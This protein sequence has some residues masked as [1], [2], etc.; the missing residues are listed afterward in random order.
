ME[1]LG[2]IQQERMAAI[3]DRRK[4]LQRK[5]IGNVY[6]KNLQYTQL[7]KKPVLKELEN[8]LLGY[9]DLD[10]YKKH[11]E[12]PKETTP[13]EQAILRDLQQPKKH[14]RAHEV[15]QKIM[16]RNEYSDSSSMQPLNETVT[17]K[18]GL[19]NTDIEEI[20]YLN[21]ASMELLTPADSS[22]NL[23]LDP[24]V[25]T[26]FGRSYVEL[27]RERLFKKA[28]ATYTTHAQMA[29]NGYRTGN[30]PTFSMTA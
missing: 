25:D 7:N 16:D 26:I 22:N 14:V 3:E 11:K 23:K 10:L 30:E 13:Q 21:D 24:F 29:K 17:S 2:V 20:A 5:N 28:I 12:E 19:K 9:K 6:R 15:T 18:T 4:M 8:L 1:S 27:Y